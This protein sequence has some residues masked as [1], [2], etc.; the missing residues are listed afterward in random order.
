VLVYKNNPEF[1]A[2]NMQ[3]V[4]KRHGKTLMGSASKT[5]MT[6]TTLNGHQSAR[7][8]ESLDI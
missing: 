7:K 6:E 3:C 2:E 5:T 4:S 8:I 1:N